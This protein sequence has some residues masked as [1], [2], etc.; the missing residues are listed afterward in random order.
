MPTPATFDWGIM[1][2]SS[3][4]SG[5]TDDA[6]MHVNMVAVKRKI[7]VSFNGADKDVCATILQA[8]AP[9]YFSV[10]YWD[11]Q[12]GQYETRTFYVGDRS[13]PFKSWWVGSERVE[14][15]S[16]DIIER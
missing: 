9:E 16:F 13:A 15:L 8:V 7:A 1:T 14:K 6:L 5:R 10:Y 11:L 4:E 2:V 3:G 12:D